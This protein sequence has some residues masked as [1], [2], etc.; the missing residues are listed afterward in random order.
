MA[1]IKP[2]EYTDYFLQSAEVVFVMNKYTIYFIFRKLKKR[3]KIY[4]QRDSNW[5]RVFVDLK[6]YKYLFC[7]RKFGFF[8]FGKKC[9]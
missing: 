5:I 2:I 3:R 1:Y 8:K 9:M 6:K 4:C 7:V